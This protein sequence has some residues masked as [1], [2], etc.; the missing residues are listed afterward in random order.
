MIL[1][2]VKELKR[3]APVPKGIEVKAVSFDVKPT[4]GG[5]TSTLAE[6]KSLVFAWLQSEVKL[7]A[8]KLNKADNFKAT[9]LASGEKVSASLILENYEVAGMVAFE[10]QSVVPF[11]RGVE[12]TRVRA[13]ADAEAIRLEVS[14]FMESKD[15]TRAVHEIPRLADS[16]VAEFLEHSKFQFSVDDTVTTNSPIRITKENVKK[17]PLAQSHKA[18]T[19]PI[20]GFPD[21]ETG[22]QQAV[23]LAEETAGLAEVLVVAKDLFGKS[24]RSFFVY[25][26]DGSSSVEW[27]QTIASKYRVARQVYLRGL[28]SEVFQTAWRQLQN[29][30]RVVDAKS[31]KTVEAQ[32][33]DRALVADLEGQ[34]EEW[35]NR[36]AQVTAERD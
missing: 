30:K 21:T 17:S 28:R 25:W 26:R 34:I 23:R 1:G 2:E 20:I 31:A 11:Y 32:P 6:L 19:L 15:P 36:T 35:K 18:H 7:P 3:G 27:H 13:L 9:F 22:N 12:T 8:S 5:G 24:D 4:G 10:L 14:T 29:A 33:V 16:L